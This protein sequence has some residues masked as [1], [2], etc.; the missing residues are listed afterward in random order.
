[1]TFV[2]AR[3]FFVCFSVFVDG[4][5]AFWMCFRVLL[6][7]VLNFSGVLCCFG[8]VAVFLARVLLLR[9]LLACCCLFCLVICGLLLSFWRFVLFV[10]LI[11]A[12][13]GAVLVF[14][15]VV[16][17]FGTP[18]PGATERDNGDPTREVDAAR[19]GVGGRGRRVASSRPG[20]PRAMNSSAKACACAA[21]ESLDPWG[22]WGLTRRVG[23]RK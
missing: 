20:A 23:D 3:A 21:R 19:K 22:V 6:G 14:F 16:W 5:G 1:M 9:F 7:V 8:V 13:F 4:V 10:D 2:G 11:C 15:C 12:L 17:Q 18:S